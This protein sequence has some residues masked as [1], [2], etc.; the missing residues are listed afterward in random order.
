MSYGHRS[1]CKALK[2]EA[3]DTM[4]CDCTCTLVMSIVVEILIKCLNSFLLRHVAISLKL[5]AY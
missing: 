5:S 3:V 4:S 2:V 1:Y